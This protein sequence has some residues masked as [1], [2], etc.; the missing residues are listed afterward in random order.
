MNDGEHENEID[1]HTEGDVEKLRVEAISLRGRLELRAVE[2]SV[3]RVA[4][5]TIGRCANAQGRRFTIAIVA[6]FDDPFGDVP[7]T[8]IFVA[9]P[10]WDE[11]ALGK[12]I[13]STLAPILTEL[14]EA[15][16]V[17][18]RAED[19]L[20]VLAELDAEGVLESTY[21][22]DP[23]RMHDDVACDDIPPLE[24]ALYAWRNAGH[25]VYAGDALPTGSTVIG[26]SG[27]RYVVEGDIDSVPVPVEPGPV[28]IVPGLRPIPGG[29]GRKP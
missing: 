20:D 2:V 26:Q 10:G 5:D 6:V 19:L 24:A 27:R 15:R 1:L 14:A 13:G 23:Q 18:P 3:L 4:I 8:S 21:N 28:P 25:P 12:A 17:E 9:D 22:L 29:K 11:A 7:Q 16:I